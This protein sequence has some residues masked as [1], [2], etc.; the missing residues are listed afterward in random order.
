MKLFR[1]S[2]AKKR[3]MTTHIVA[4]Q[5]WFNVGAVVVAF[6]YLSRV[7]IPSVNSVSFVCSALLLLCIYETD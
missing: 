2:V 5:E 3:A 1:R 6:K 4:I 7:D